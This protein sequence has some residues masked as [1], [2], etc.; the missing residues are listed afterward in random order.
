[1]YS[2]STGLGQPSTTNYDWMYDPATPNASNY[3]SP[4]LLSRLKIEDFCSRATRALYG[5]RFNMQA[6]LGGDDR[7]SIYQV[8]EQEI[9]QLELN[10][11]STLTSGSNSSPVISFKH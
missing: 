10:T 1:M 11:M 7:S 8:L 9:C 6:T 3:L 5:S 4:E 2:T